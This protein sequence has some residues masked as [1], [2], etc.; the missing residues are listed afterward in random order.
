MQMSAT[1]L[2]NIYMFQDAEGPEIP[3]GVKSGADD[4]PIT[5]TSDKPYLGEP[6]DPPMQMYENCAKFNGKKLLGT[7]FL[8][9]FIILS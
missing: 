3:V 5:N 2:K 9:Y 6:D 7:F 1:I 8:P 4:D